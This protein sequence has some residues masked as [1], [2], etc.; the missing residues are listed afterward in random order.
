MDRE[1]CP[2]KLPAFLEEKFSNNEKEGED[3]G[4]RTECPVCFLSV[5]KR[6]NFLYILLPLC[7]HPI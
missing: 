5:D 4:I 1:N 3:A 6:K 7:S 2:E